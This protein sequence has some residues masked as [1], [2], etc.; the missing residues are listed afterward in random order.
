MKHLNAGKFRL[1]LGKKT[2]VMGILNFTPDSFSDGGDYFSAQKAAERAAQ[3]EALGADIIDIGAN[4][5]RPGAEILDAKSELARLES[6]L[7]AVYGA[8]N[9]PVS[10]DTFYPE[11]AEYALRSGAGIINDVSGTFNPE[12]AELVKQ[13]DAS[14]VVT[15]NPCG[16]SEVQDY[17]GSVVAA[18]RSFFLECIGRAAQCSLPLEALCLDPGIGF[19]KSDEDNLEIIRNLNWLKINPCA[20]LFA[21][22]RKRVTALNRTDPKDR[23]FSSV[24]ANTAAVAGGA[25]IIRVH[26]I[27]AGVDC[28]RMADR[29]YRQNGE[30]NG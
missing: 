21:A 20:L 1:E 22:S 18:V 27:T 24:S 25:D 6:V 16:A 30:N 4:S 15:H 7:P 12:I 11:C 19:G 23:D 10:V 5:T 8:V 17:N 14:L 2:L 9:I 26:N 3:I 28:A 29:I 13:Y